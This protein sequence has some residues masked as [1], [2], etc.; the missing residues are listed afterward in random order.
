MSRPT[1]SKSIGQYSEPLKIFV[2]KKDI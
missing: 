2:K 1:V